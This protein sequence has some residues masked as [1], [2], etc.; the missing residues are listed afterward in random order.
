M[1]NQFLFGSELMVAPITQPMDAEARLACVTAWLPEGIWFD[2]SNGLKI[3][4]NR[5]LTLWRPLS[6][7]P[8]LA[9]AGAIVPLTGEEESRRNGVALPLSLEVRVFGGA[10]GDFML[11]EDDGETM[12]YEAGEVAATCFTLRW[13]AEGTT[14]FT[15][16][17]DDEKP[18]L[19]KHRDY[20]IAF[21]GV[22]EN[23]T[24]RVFYGSG[25]SLPYEVDYNRETHRLTVSLRGLPCSETVTL[26]FAQPPD[27]CAK[28][29]CSPAA[30]KF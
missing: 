2:C 24:L 19:P 17:A 3:E 13:R 6:Q 1:P 15:L 26:V 25:A 23:D 27:P 16:C 30:M 28:T 10:D 22:E 21:Y 20:V 12:A 14:C 8:V 9:K 4:G 7:M 5:R 11:Y 18:F 29:T